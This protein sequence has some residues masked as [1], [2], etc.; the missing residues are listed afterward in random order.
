MSFKTF[1]QSLMRR[2]SAGGKPEYATLTWTAATSC[3]AAWTAQQTPLLVNRLPRLPLPGCT[4]TDQCR[5]EF[6]DWRD[7]RVS[8]RRIPGSA[9]TVGIL[10]RTRRD[11]RLS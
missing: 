1:V 5:C 4:I 6:R 7:R 9:R 3:R 11:R 2:Y 10:Q 8:E